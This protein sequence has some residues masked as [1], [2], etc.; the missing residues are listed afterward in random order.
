MKKYLLIFSLL[1]LITPIF[2]NALSPVINSITVGNLT[3]DEFS[4]PAWV[5]IQS[6]PVTWSGSSLG[7][8][9]GD[10]A[11]K[12]AIHVC[13]PGDSSVCVLGRQNGVTLDQVSSN[14]A[15]GGT[16]NMIIGDLLN[17]NYTNFNKYFDARGRTSVRICPQPIKDA[18]IPLSS[19]TCKSSNPFRLISLASFSGVTVEGLTT[20][21][22]WGKLDN[23]KINWSSANLSSD[24]V[25]EIIA[26]PLGLADS[27][28]SSYCKALSLSNIN[29]YSVGLSQTG[30]YATVSLPSNL[31]G[32]DLSLIFCKTG[33]GRRVCNPANFKFTVNC[34]PNWTT[35]AWSTCTSGGTQTRAVTDTNSCG[36][37]T[38]K[39]AMSQSCTCLPNWSTGAWSACFGGIQTRAVADTNWCGVT[40]GQPA[41][42][43][44]CT[45]IPNWNTGTWSACFDGTQTRIVADQYNCGVT[46]GKPAV[47]QSCACIPDWGIGSWSTCINGTQTRIVADQNN[48]GVTA[49]K[50]AVSQSCGAPICTPNWTTSAWSTCTSGG[51]QTRAV[52]DTNSCGLTTNKPAMSQSCTSTCTPNWSASAWSTC[53]NGTQTRIVADQN[54]CGVTTELTTTQS[55]APVDDGPDVYVNAVPLALAGSSLP[56]TDNGFRNGTGNCTVVGNEAFTLKWTTYDAKTCLGL[57]RAIGGGQDSDV[58]NFPPATALGLAGSVNNVRLQ[59]LGEYELSIICADSQ[60]I[61]ASGAIRIKSIIS[62][63]APNVAKVEVLGLSGPT[64]DHW[65]VNT[66]KTLNWN[67]ANLA[68]VALFVCHPQGYVATCPSFSTTNN[69]TC[70]GCIAGVAGGNP[71]IN[72]TS[73]SAS[74]TY[75]LKIGNLLT[76]TNPN[77]QKILGPSNET[78]LKSTKVA[79]CPSSGVGV[80]NSSACG[81]TAPF[82]LLPPG[83]GVAT[84]GAKGHGCV[85]GTTVK[86]NGVSQTCR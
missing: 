67:G 32:N 14:S 44:P 40:T 75:L 69:Y 76:N 68:K 65:L 57:A 20:G 15:T 28:A 64:K 61:I 5:A 43:Q 72:I 81:Y 74:G 27:Y 71:L 9:A 83:G 70:G 17:T 18:P 22:V 30:G 6:K 66:G 2:A 47:S 8:Y 13:Y 59:S 82:K 1:I 37:T 16:F 26:C 73:N 25:L 84:M 42:S 48:C 80:A 63:N 24:S 52:T 60:N 45:C 77:I 34:T 19:S 50:P 55:C 36:L 11:G 49:G 23:H 39:P 56:C 12:V 58:S 31:S 51:T 35:S 3:T 33:T 54:N 79:I 41:T 85:I 46:A 21:G 86:I 78:G 38:N 29:I 62:P 7:A 53:I 10:Q 4:Q